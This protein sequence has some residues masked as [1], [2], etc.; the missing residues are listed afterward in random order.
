MKNE[1]LR[2]KISKFFILNSSFINDF[3]L[4]SYTLLMDSFKHFFN[5]FGI[6]AAE[7]AL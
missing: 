5:A 4:L 3:H 2:M 1:E 6:D 7:R